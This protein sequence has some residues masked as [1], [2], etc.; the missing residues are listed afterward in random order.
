M[1]TVGLAKRAVVPRQ[2]GPDEPVDTSPR[3]C[4]C[5]GQ[6]VERD[7]YSTWCLRCGKRKV[8]K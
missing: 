8:A 1:T 6:L 2:A 4:R 7:Q 3:V 5:D